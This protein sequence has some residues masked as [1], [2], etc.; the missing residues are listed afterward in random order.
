MAER[1]KYNVDD[2]R[3]QSNIL[4]LKETELKIKNSILSLT[5]EIE[6]KNKQVDELTKKYNE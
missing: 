6:L 3:L 4:D 5:G 1:E 2:S